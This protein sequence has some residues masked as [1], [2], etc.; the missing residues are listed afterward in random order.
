MKGGCNFPMGP[1][2]LLDLVGLDTSL[3]I[4]DALY[5]EFRDPN[6]AAVPHAA[7]HGQP[8]ATSAASPGTGFYDYAQAEPRRRVDGASTRADRA[9]ADAVAA[10]RPRRRPT[11][12]ASSASA[13]TSSRARCSP[14]TAPAC[15]RC[16]SAR[17]P[18]SAGGRPTRAACSRSTGC[19]SA[20]RCASRAAASRSAS[21]RA[22]DDGDRR[23]APT[24]AGRGGWITPDIR[25]RLRRAARAR[26]GA[27]RRGVDDDGELV[28]GLYGVRI[29]G[30]FAGESMFHRAHRRVEGRA[31]RP[32]RL[33][34]RRPAPTLLDVQWTTPHLARSARSTSR[35]RV[36]AP[37]GR[38]RRVDRAGRLTPC[39][40]DRRA[41]TAVTMRAMSDDAQRDQPW[42]MRT[43]S[44]H[45]TATASN[46]LYR[47]NL[48][49]GQ[50]GLS[51]AFDLPT[52]TGY[53]PDDP[54]ARGEVGKVG[55]PVAHLGHM[56]TLLDG[57]P[58][59]EMNTSMTINATGGVAARPLRRQRRGAGR[60]RRARCGAPRR[61]TSSR[62]TC[63]RG[64]Y[65]FPPLPSPPAD[66][67]HGRVLR[68]ARARSGTR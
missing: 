64:T 8:P 41:T 37:P 12:T 48:A 63:R 59:G 62:S 52:Q 22:F 10:S 3:A 67:R 49:K 4:L 50:T 23:A 32:R 36:P 11:T 61:T 53:D 16:R 18:R 30:L 57:I 20:A 58:P 66:R 7:P 40:V 25:R 47:T 56:R 15:S 43:Y 1:F 26:L 65:I 60:R 46:E 51:I 38:R 5:D 24:R 44:G 54:L 45:S 29:G 27:Q 55:V 21:T 68:R 2:A 31:R 9:A 33:A 35:V 39:D 19:A 6:Y 17:R 28:G 34:A 13:P 42:L 14:P